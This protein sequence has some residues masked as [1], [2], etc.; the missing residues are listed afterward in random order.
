[1]LSLFRDVIRER[2]FD[3]QDVHVSLLELVV[4]ERRL[5]DQK[6]V[7][8][9]SQTPQVDSFVVR[10]LFNHFRR[11]IVQSSTQSLPSRRRTVNS[12]SKIGDFQFA[13]VTN[14]DVFWFQVT[15]NDFPQMTVFERLDELNQVLTV[16]L[17]KITKKIINYNSFD[18]FKCGV[19][20]RT[21]ADVGSSNRT[22]LRSF[23]CSS[24]CGAYSRT[25]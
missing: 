25:K 16:P 9:N 24:P 14:Q 11:Q 20:I 15:M 12:P 1:M 2:I 4:N 8:Q 17:R 23:L 18:R 6:L 3:K 5:S 7:R 13:I 21:L 10:V 22:R 19:S